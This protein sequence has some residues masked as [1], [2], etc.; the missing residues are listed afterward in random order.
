MEA[1]VLISDSVLEVVRKY[2]RICVLKRLRMK[3]KKRLRMT[4]NI[5]FLRI[6]YSLYKMSKFFPFAYYKGVPQI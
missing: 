3:K 5:S 4:F 6:L 2:W 1:S